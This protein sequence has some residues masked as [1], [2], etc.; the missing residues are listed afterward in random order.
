MIDILKDY[1]ERG[2]ITLRP[3]KEKNLLIANYTQKVQFER[4]WDEITL[5]CRGLI[6]DLNGNVVARPFS[7]FFN[8]EEH[9]QE[10]MQPIPNEPFD[11]F[12]KLD[13]S[14]GIC[15]FWDGKWQIATRGSFDSE[16]AVKG[17]VLLRKT[18]HLK[19]PGYT[20]L[21]EI[22]YPKNRIVVDYGDREE[23][24]LLSIIET[25]TGREIPLS[26]DIFP[27]AKRYNGIKDISQLKEL[28][29]QEDEGFVVRF[30]SGL[31]VKVK[32]S[33]YVRLHRILT[34]VSTKSI[35]DALRN[36]QSLDE[37]LERVPDE[38]F[39]WVKDTKQELLDEFH[40]IKAYA[41]DI[42]AE[43]V[44][45]YPN[46]T[47]KEFAEWAKTTDCTHLLFSLLNGKDID[48]QIWKNLKPKYE[49]PFKVEA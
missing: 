25:D 35:W 31:R 14:L 41:Q 43:H 33:E 45:N 27:K 21:Y 40:G 20:Y 16:Q 8:L 2:L 19:F 24:V 10:G 13:G 15:F 46:E 44:S 39:Q 28:K 36:N 38:F 5:Q 4:L 11:V 42:Y 34:Q 23:L 12:E 7:K 26:D 18:Q 17:N 3:N 48:Q 22:I 49:K 9:N 37:I 6:V 29:N 30:K 32:F 1:S 47:R